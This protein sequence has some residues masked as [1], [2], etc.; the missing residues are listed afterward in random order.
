MQGG[1][2]YAHNERTC[3]G[4]IILHV[5]NNLLIKIQNNE[6]FCYFWTFLYLFIGPDNEIK[7]QVII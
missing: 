3:V 5:H 6:K 7:I 1:K 2:F 4:I